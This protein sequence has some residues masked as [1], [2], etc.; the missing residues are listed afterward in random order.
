MRIW[1]AVIGLGCAASLAACM[2]DD[3]GEPALTCDLANTGR[4]LEGDWSLTGRGRR[5]GCSD[6]RLE[7][8]LTLENPRA[9][10]VRARPEPTQGPATGPEVDF[11]ADAFVVR[12]QRADYVLELEGG[13]DGVLGLQGGAVGSCVSFSLSE[14]LED[15]DRL[16]YRFDGYITDNHTV[17]GDFWGEGP[18][19]CEVTGT[20]Q[21]EV[22]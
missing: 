17:S 2:G 20:F 21:L 1:L 5:E 15:G 8:D 16:R 22:R 12:I 10:G 18:E 11:E 3:T 19:S 7:G 4:A 13:D 9:F 14:E 6:R